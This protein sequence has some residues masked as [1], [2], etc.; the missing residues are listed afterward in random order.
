[1]NINAAIQQHGAVAV[2]RAAYQALQGDYT[3]LAR[4]GLEC[5]KLS[6]AYAVMS[7]AYKQMDEA[8]RAID[9]A[10]TQSLLSDHDQLGGNDDA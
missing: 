3:P 9:N 7:A 10:Q 4:L 5:S 1:M 8:E 6:E 2:H